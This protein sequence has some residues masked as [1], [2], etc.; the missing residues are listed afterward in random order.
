M[1]KSL[2]GNSVI[3]MI[4]TVIGLLVPLITFPYVARVLT[5]ETIGKVS[6]SNSIISYFSLLAGLG[7]FTFAV[8]EGTKIRDDRKQWD[9]FASEI[10]TF[11]LIT[12]VI[13]YVLFLVLLLY[14]EKWQN[15]SVIMIILSVSIPLAT[16]GVDWIFTVHEEFLYIT[17]RSLCMQLLSVVYL[18]LFVKDNSDIFHY[19]LYTVFSGVGAN[20]VNFFRA[21]KYVTLKLRITARVKT[22]L[23]PI[24]L[25]FLSSFA[26]QIYINSDITILGYLATDR[27]VGLYEIAVRI[28]N[29]AK[30]VLL[31]LGVV[32]MPRLE[33]LVERDPMSYEKLFS[34][35]FNVNTLLVVPAAIGLA[36]VGEDVLV[37]FAGEQYAQSYAYL[38]ILAFAL[39]FCILNSYLS[40]GNLVLHGKEKQIF[41]T[42]VIGAILN[43]VLNLLLI[44]LLGG[45][46]AAA[47]TLLAEAVGM[48]I[49]LYNIS[50]YHKICGVGKHLLQVLLA[51]LGMGVVCL[52]V[53]FS[54]QTLLLRL[55]AVIAAGVAT[56]FVTLLLMHN[57]LFMEGIRTLLDKRRGAK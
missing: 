16:L 23:K 15:Y 31:A 38:A 11:N 41:I 50:R 53:S 8:R 52:L 57:E 49:H 22:Y 10:F 33:N 45:V 28:Y 34:K 3:Y 44:P 54:V 26:T 51:A 25:I 21:R 13:S 27:D 9:L 2:A 14:V 7:I 1:K 42:A 43:A 39:P 18:L 37:L 35:L 36:I 40:S 30:T 17:I 56:Y 5:V 47:T 4:K 29:I 32:S 48:V 6:F 24:L 46:A 20:V 19:A 12:T 55:F